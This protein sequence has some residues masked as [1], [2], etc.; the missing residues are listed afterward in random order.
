M[1]ARASAARCGA[2]PGR[3][4]PSLPALAFGPVCRRGV[5]PGLQRRELLVDAVVV[6]EFVDLR[7]QGLLADVIGLDHPLEVVELAL[8][9]LEP[10]QGV[11]DVVLGELAADAEPRLG[12]LPAHDEGRSGAPWR[13]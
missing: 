4:G 7:G 8:V 12:R 13:P 6:L 11:V 2:D 9:E 10:V 5:H 1:W 3:A